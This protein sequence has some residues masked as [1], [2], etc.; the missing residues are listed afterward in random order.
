MK[1]L[2]WLLVACGVVVLLLANTCLAQVELRIT[3]PPGAIPF[4]PTQRVKVSPPAQD[5][6]TSLVL[7]MKQTAATETLEWAKTKDQ[8]SQTAISATIAGNSATF[9]LPKIELNRELTIEYGFKRPAA[10]AGTVSFVAS[11]VVFLD[12][13]PPKLRSPSLEVT[14]TGSATVTL[15]FS[16]SDVRPVSVSADS[17]LL[18][19]KVRVEGEEALRN[20][21]RQASQAPN[22][23]NQNRQVRIV[24]DALSPGDYELRVQNM[25]DIVGNTIPALGD[26][27]AHAT[28]PITIPV[29]PQRATQPE[30]PRFLAEGDR[31]SELNPGDRVDT[32]VVQL[33]YLRDARQVAELINRN[34]QDLN[35]VS[36]DAAQR[37]AADARKRAEDAIDNRRFQDERAVEAARRSRETETRLQ[38]AQDELREVQRDQ[39]A[40]SQ[41]QAELE[42]EAYRMTGKKGSEIDSEINSLITEVGANRT[43][44]NDLNTRI[45]ENKNKLARQEKDGTPMAD[46]L[47][48]QKEISDLENERDKKHADTT[49]AIN[50]ASALRTLKGNIDATSA[51]QTSLQARNTA[52]TD[53]TRTDRLPSQLAQ[54]QQTEITERLKVGQAEATELRASQEQFRREVAAGLADRNSYARGSLDS[55][56]PVAQVSIAVVGTSRLQLRG[57]IKGLNK[58]CRMIHQLDSPVGQVKIGIHTIQVNGEHGDRMDVVYERINREVA[59][60]RFLVNASGQFLRRAV[61]EVA[62]EVAIEADAG[63]LPPNCPPELQVGV[64]RLNGAIQTSQELRDRRYLYAFYGSDFIGELEEMDSELLNTDNKLLSLHS[65]DTISLPGAMFVLAHADHPVRHRVLM[66][67]QELIA[68]DLPMREMEYVRALTQLDSCGRPLKYNPNRANKIDE[69]EARAIMYNNGRTYTF[70]NTVGFFNNQ[71][72]SQGT[73]NPVQ[74]ATVKLAQ[75]LKAQLV[76][77]MEYRNL[78]A[79]RTLLKDKL[80]KTEAKLREMAQILQVQENALSREAANSVEKLAADT[81]ELGDNNTDSDVSREVRKQLNKQSP[82]LITKILF[83]AIMKSRN[84]CDQEFGEEVAETVEQMLDLEEGSLEG[85]FIGGKAEYLE[86]AERWASITEERDSIDKA[87]SS[88][89]REK[90]TL[91][92][93]LTGRQAV[94]QF[95]DEQEEKSVELMEA[96]RAHSSN[97]DNYLKRLAIAVEDDVA[98]Q[99]YEPAFQRI[100]TVSR[101][102]DVTLGQIETTTILTNNRTLAKVSPAASFEF[103]LPERRIL[104]TEAMQGAKALAD[105]YGN[106]LKDPTFVSGSELLRSRTAEGITGANNAYTT[107]PGTD[108][109]PEFGS[110]LDKLIQPPAIY[111][112]ETGTGFEVRPVIQPDGNSV[113]YTF[114]YEYTTNVREPVRADE[115]H[116]G[117]IKRHFV[118]TEVQTSSYELREVSR[119]TVSLK[120]ARTDRGVPLLEDIPVFGQAFRPLPSEESSLQTNIILGSSTIYPTVYDLMGL[121][122]SPFVDGEGVKVLSSEKTKTKERADALRQYLRRRVEADLQLDE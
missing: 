16:D 121:R 76:A 63:I 57:P 105:E 96:L 112:F 71:I 117:R 54:Q 68:G 87:I 40:I 80:D 77:E 15:D 119:Y 20:R 118:H 101:T 59:H 44:I 34:I 3:T 9:A 32:R 84:K 45:R 103:D 21:P 12:S 4:G 73:L 2:Q 83:S 25:S 114:D 48:T 14:N 11:E 89:S 37:A 30:Y 41:T 50:K 13:E 22:L 90:S 100:R 120:A 108:N 53:E 61:Q 17:F 69:K 91:R 47:V 55:I 31:P 109:T 97:I 5:A 104:I 98:A 6:S 46:Q 99:F 64:V 70:P 92:E 115:K 56:D 81:L 107:I 26:S 8:R 51:A 66:R 95:M 10:G 102:W 79:E 116:L 58:I 74:Y 106:L 35:A 38:E 82:A 67:F 75:A 65:M 18:F 29:R 86:L 23:F 19:E 7:T 36:W 72:Q 113:M 27:G 24:W 94:E 28:I 60:S 110:E 42:A 62:D 43:A 122:W 49:N 111:K 88:L 85:V 1:T 78:V 52:L 93:K 39:A 33:Y